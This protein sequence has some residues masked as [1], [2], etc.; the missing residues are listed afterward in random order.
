MDM[1]S[2]VFEPITLAF[3]Y[4]IAIFNGK[5][6]FFNSRHVQ[7]GLVTQFIE[8]PIELQRVFAASNM[9]AIPDTVKEACKLSDI[10]TKGNAAGFF[11][12]TTF[13]GLSES[14][15]IVGA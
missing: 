9:K 8:A 15:F 11:D 13:T 1:P 5:H 7:S 3:G 12:T 4:F 10:P 2:S 14:P 6:S